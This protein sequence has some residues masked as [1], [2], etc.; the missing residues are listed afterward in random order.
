MTVTVGNGAASGTIFGYPGNSPL[1][2][3]G[4]NCTLGV[5]QGLIYGNPLVWSVPVMPQFVGTTLAVQGFTLIGS[6]CL[7]SIDL[8]DTVYF[9]LR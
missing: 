7:A 6:Q 3:L 2:A 8:S 5:S 1:A 9:T 4:C